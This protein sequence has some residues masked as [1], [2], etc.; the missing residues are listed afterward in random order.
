MKNKIRLSKSRLLSLI[1]V[2]V[3]V[4][5]TFSFNTITTYA[6]EYY[7]GDVNNDKKINTLDALLILKQSAGL[8]ELS[9][10]AK[11]AGDVN[12]DKKTNTLDALTVLK[13]SAN[14]IT[15]LNNDQ[16][17]LPKKIVELKKN[18]SENIN[19]IIPLN[20]IVTYSSDNEQIAKVTSDG[21]IFAIENGVVKI[22]ITCKISL[23][24]GTFQEIKNNIEVIIED[25]T[26]K[27]FNGID[28]SVWQGKIDWNKVKLSNIDF[29]ILRAGFGWKTADEENYFSQRDNEFLNNYEGAK[30]NNIPV[31]VY[32]YAYARTPQEAVLEAEYLMSIIKDKTFE[33]PI[34]Y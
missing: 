19:L 23:N 33:Y 11:M 14:V 30:A 6:E 16:I 20:S 3:T 25:E 31:G 10:T 1:L 28:V 4:F 8:L 17:Y 9:Q 15:S 22:N 34:F 18:K 13:L 32:H 27:I 12:N 24:D 21:T 7:I 2:I 26:E 29:A 5:T